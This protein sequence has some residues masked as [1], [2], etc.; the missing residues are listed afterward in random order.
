VTTRID[1]TVERHYLAEMP[2]L[3]DGEEIEMPDDTAEPLPAALDL[4]A[5]MA[6]A[7]A[8]ALPPWPRADD[9]ELERSTFAGPGTRAMTDEEARP[10]AGLKG[11]L[12][13]RDDDT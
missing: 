1:E 13:K 6:E 12:D 3:P 4:G 10:F 9:A 5:V 8:I 11:L 7:L 2:D